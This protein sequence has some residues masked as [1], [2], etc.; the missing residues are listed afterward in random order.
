MLY[1]KYNSICSALI[2][3]TTPQ[4]QFY[5][6]D[7]YA[8]RLVG[9]AYSIP[10]V[11]IILRRL[12]GMFASKRYEGYTY[13]FEWKDSGPEINDDESGVSDEDDAQLFP[14]PMA[15][16]SMPS[17][18]QPDQ[19]EQHDE[20]NQKPSANFCV[21]R[22]EVRPKRE[23]DDQK[24]P[25][26]DD[27]VNDEKE[28]PTARVQLKSQ[29]NPPAAL[30]GREISEECSLPDKPIVAEVCESGIPRPNN[31]PPSCQVRDLSEELEDI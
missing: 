3:A 9:N 28:S 27:G 23:D 2:I 26:H 19:D 8:K 25:A 30:S 7:A 4:P 22:K 20:E 15:V 12:Q 16:A 10:V 21:P 13:A 29:M 17:H 11:D 1:M 31:T 5:N 24:P 18:P 6:A 14:A